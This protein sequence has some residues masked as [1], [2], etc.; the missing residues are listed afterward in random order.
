MISGKPSCFSTARTS[1]PALPMMHFMM[2][3]WRLMVL[4]MGSSLQPCRAILSFNMITPL[5]RRLFLQR[6]KKF[7]RSLS[8]RW[9]ERERWTRSQAKDNNS[10]QQRYLSLLGYLSP[11]LFLQVRTKTFPRQTES[12]AGYTASCINWPTAVWWSR[13]LLKKALRP[14]LRLRPDRKLENN[15]CLR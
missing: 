12:V 11:Y 5:G 9:P 1:R 10:S 15:A 8:V 14:N 4:S 2:S 3:R 6:I 13:Q 7:I